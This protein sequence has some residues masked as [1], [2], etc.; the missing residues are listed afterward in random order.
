MTLSFWTSHA[1]W[2]FITGLTST[3]KKRIYPFLTMGSTLQI[4]KPLFQLSQ[5]YK[6]QRAAHQQSTLFTST[7]NSWRLEHSSVFKCSTDELLYLY[8]NLALKYSI[9]LFWRGEGGIHCTDASPC[10]KINDDISVL[11]SPLLL[12][13][14]TWV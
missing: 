5:R 14:Q 12:A 2:P 11:S 10:S 8:I 13:T 1:S 4:N 3:V 6:P 9:G 7:R